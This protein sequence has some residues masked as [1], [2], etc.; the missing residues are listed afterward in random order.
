MSN[1]PRCP[2]YQSG[3]ALD[4]D[5]STPGQLRALIFG[6]MGTSG[7]T[8]GSWTVGAQ[9]YAALGPICGVPPLRTFRG[10]KRTEQQALRARDDQRRA[11]WPTAVSQER[12]MALASL[13]VERFA[14]TASDAAAAVVQPRLMACSFNI[15]C[16]LPTVRSTIIRAWWLEVDEQRAKKC[17]PAR[18]PTLRRCGAYASRRFRDET[19]EPAVLAS[20]PGSG[21]TWTRMLL[22][23]GSG[24]YTGSVYDDVDLMRLMPAEG[25]DTGAVIAVKAHL[26][27]AKYMPQ[28]TAARI[29]LLVRHPFDAIWSEYQRRVSGGHAARASERDFFS[30]SFA[31][32]AKCMACKWIRYAMMHADL[33]SNDREVR[34][35]RY[36][37]MVAATAPTLKSMLGFLKVGDDE[38]T[39]D[40]LSCAAELSVDPTIKRAKKRPAREMFGN[41]SDLACQI[42]G[43]ISQNAAARLL[44]NTLGYRNSATC[45]SKAP[46]SHFCDLEGV[47]GMTEGKGDNCAAGGGGGARYKGAAASSPRAGARPSALGVRSSSAMVVSSSTAS[48]RSFGGLAKP[49]APPAK[50]PTGGGLGGSRERLR[51]AARDRIDEYRGTKAAPSSAESLKRRFADARARSGEPDAA[52]RPAAAPPRPALRGAA[53]SGKA[54]AGAGAAAPPQTAR[55]AAPPPP[56]GGANGARTAA[57]TSTA[58]AAPPPAAAGAERG[59]LSGTPAERK[60][61]AAERS[62]IARQRVAERSAATAGPPRAA[63]DAPR[64]PGSPRRT[65]AAARR[66]LARDDDFDAHAA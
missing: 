36:E 52:P 60:A 16:L 61:A 8:M 4:H 57:R 65:P 63:A 47:T 41:H 15:N 64:A 32:F 39:D 48:S 50:K 45:A 30:S 42:W 25:V 3:N 59:A 66:A 46:S 19:A 28:T 58:A 38:L 55:S 29:L 12:K 14:E 23:Y 1:H 31:V 21:N 24:I 56:A 5:V 10:P 13:I 51:A 11:T 54:A 6:T 9:Q 26:N 53:A 62:R 33:A 37:D 27:P 44:L 20:F 40:R 17:C 2:A 43:Q 22:E 35:V 34:V 49:K 7:G 18:L